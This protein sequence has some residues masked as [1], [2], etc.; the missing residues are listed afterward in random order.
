MSQD[1]AWS[2]VQGSWTGV[3]KVMEPIQSLCKGGAEH[4]GNNRKKDR[5]ED[6]TQQET[7]N[8]GQPV[9]FS[10]AHSP[11]LPQ[12]SSPSW[13]LCYTQI[14]WVWSQHPTPQRLPYRA[15]GVLDN[16]A[17]RQWSRGATGQ[18]VSHVTIAFQ[19][20]TVNVFSSTTHCLTPCPAW[21]VPMNPHLFHEEKCQVENAPCPLQRSCVSFLSSHHLISHLLIQ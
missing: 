4:S 6:S 14:L 16:N 20:S 13:R 9:I 21:P 15:A 2:S 10:P 3:E 18:L 11:S 17:N 8:L 1:A 7:K 5:Q 12:Y 19:S